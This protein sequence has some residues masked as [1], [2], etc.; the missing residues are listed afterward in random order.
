MA[1]P[2]FSPKK[3]DVIRLRSEPPDAWTSGLIV[4]GNSDGKIAVEIKGVLRPRDG[5]NAGGVVPLLIDCDAETVQY[6]AGGRFDVEVRL[7]EGNLLKQS[8]RHRR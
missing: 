6:L 7:S 4:N 8:M 3:G 5:S 1:Q 2:K